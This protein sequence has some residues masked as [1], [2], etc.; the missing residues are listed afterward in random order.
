MSILRLAFVMVLL[1]SGSLWASIGKVALVKGEAHVQ[2]DV[3]KVALQNG[4]SIEEKD[5]ITTAKEAQVQ[6]VFE[7]KTVITLGSESEFKIE[8]YL[9]DA[10]NPK[11]KFK[12]NQGSFKTI[13]GQ[14][15]KTAPQN[16]TM[17]TKTATI[18]IRGTIVKGSTGDKGDVIACL[19][20]LITVMSRHTNQVVEVP[21]G[22]FTTIRGNEPPSTPQETKPGTTDD[23]LANNTPPPTSPA[24]TTVASVE[25]TK[26]DG[27]AQSIFATRGLLSG[28]YAIEGLA[29]SSSETLSLSFSVDRA[30]AEMTGSLS[31]SDGAIHSLNLSGGDF[32]IFNSVEQELGVVVAT[33]PWVIDGVN[34]IILTE[35]E[36]YNLSVQKG[37]LTKEE[38]DIINDHAKISVDILNEL[39][40]PKKYKEIPQISGNHHEKIS[41]KGYPQGL[42]GDEISFEAR[43][44]AIADVFEALT[45]SDRPYK[46]GNP[47]SSAMKIL[48]FMAKDDEL[49]KELVKFFYNS[50]LYL[51]Y[52]QELLPQSSIDEVT[53][54][55]GT[56]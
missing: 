14:I 36:A 56:L 15:G 12:F 23:S 21:A 13:T 39:P 55:F 43:I 40:F 7:D 28:T 22:Q 45:A 4:S 35:N 53:V 46:K 3:Q 16:F 25:Q 33:P 41:G 6:L 51:Q 5:I 42:K 32:V 37:T 54:D 24:P 47:L 48:Y 27:L 19:R 49:D 8:E 34:Y 52:A 26:N 18:G 17:E 31:N 10:T 2:R 29:T 50:G 11:A 44:L 38:R 30:T 20:G 9:N 1:L